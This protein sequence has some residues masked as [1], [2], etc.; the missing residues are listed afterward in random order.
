VMSALTPG[1][2]RLLWGMLARLREKAIRKLGID[3]TTVY[4]PSDPGELRAG[5]RS[6][7]LQ[8]PKRLG[9]EGD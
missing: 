9:E 5:F 7:R 1:E 3:K 2:K 6:W 8:D 4:P